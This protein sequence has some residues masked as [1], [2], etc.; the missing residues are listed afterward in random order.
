[1][2]TGTIAGI[3]GCR[4]GWIAVILSTDGNWTTKLYD[5]IAGLWEAEGQA[6][7]L[8]IDMPIGL[9]SQVKAVR[10]CDIDARQLLRPKRASSIFPAP[11]REILMASEYAEANKLSKELTARGLSKQTW[12]L[13]SKIRELDKLLQSDKPAH[14]KLLESHPELCFAT[15]SG[16]PMKHNKKTQAGYEERLELLAKLYPQAE[17]IVNHT[18]AAYPRKEVSRDDIVDALVLAVSALLGGKAVEA[19]KGMESA[20]PLCLEHDTTGL[21]MQIVYYSR[22]LIQ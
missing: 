8:L 1:M 7:L 3:D 14:K 11:I 6:D 15:L 22:S 9:P 20:V 10:Q 13:M 19:M 21:P 16:A 4:A 5:C 2:P 12:H 17:V 18:L